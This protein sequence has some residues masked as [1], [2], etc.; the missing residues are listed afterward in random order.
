MV[1]ANRIFV[2][3][4]ATRT[5]D[6]GLNDID[7]GDR[8]R[9]R[10]HAGNLQCPEKLGMFIL[11]LIIY[12]QLDICTHHLSFCALNTMQWDYSYLNRSNFAHVISH[13]PTQAF[14]PLT[15]TLSIVKSFLYSLPR[16]C[17]L[18]HFTLGIPDLRNV[19]ANES[20]ISCPKLLFTY[21]SANIRICKNIHYEK[22]TFLAKYVQLARFPRIF[23]IRICE[24][25]LYFQEMQRINSY[26]VASISSADLDRISSGE[27]RSLTKLCRVCSKVSKSAFC[28]QSLLGSA[29][30]LLLALSKCQA[31]SNP[32]AT[33]HGSVGGWV[34]KAWDGGVITVSCCT[35]CVSNHIIIFSLYP[36]SQRLL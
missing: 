19:V 36:D 27:T 11:K 6:N 10:C 34:V 30:W 2:V 4:R 13:P 3:T 25:R 26:L 20:G 9:R 24:V 18:S 29:Q 23:G 35:R 33:I 28:W 31:I 22:I 17:S 32:N 16:L 21:G 1:I 5:Q 14:Q 12:I 15:F 8:Q 7:E